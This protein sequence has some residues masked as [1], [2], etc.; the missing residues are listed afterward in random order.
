MPLHITPRPHYLKRTPSASGSSRVWWCWA[1]WQPL[2]RAYGRPLGHEC[3][4]R[5]GAGVPVAFTT[6][7]CSV[8]QT[9]ELRPRR[10]SL[11]WRRRA[12]AVLEH[13]SPPLAMR[14]VAYISSYCHPCPVGHCSLP[15][16]AGWWYKSARTELLL[17]K[18]DA[19]CK[20]EKGTQTM[21][22][23]LIRTHVLMLGRLA[24]SCSCG[25][26]YASV[27]SSRSPASSTRNAL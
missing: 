6:R 23:P 18:D 14:C 11:G 27:S 13:G 10:R 9:Q 15:P 7:G 17:R 22:K 20:T 1:S 4:L 16:P 3:G 19:A 26:W 12:V 24:T 8:P 25:S 5:H 21:A 2:S